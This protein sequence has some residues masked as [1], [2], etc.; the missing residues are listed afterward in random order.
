M[1]MVTK[2]R[3]EKDGEIVNIISLLYYL[4]LGIIYYYVIMS[5][6]SSYL[7]GMILNQGSDRGWKDGRVQV[8]VNYH[9]A[10]Q[11]WWVPC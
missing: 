3:K 10:T 6:L 8:V 5:Y 2:I 7:I 9:F 11:Y 1:F 4:F